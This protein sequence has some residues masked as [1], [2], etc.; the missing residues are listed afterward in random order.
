MK[1]ILLGD[2]ITQG[3]GSRT[4][5]F[6]SALQELLGDGNTVLYG[7]V[8]GQIKPNRRGKI[9]PH[10]PGRLGAENGC[11]ILPRPFYSG[12]PVKRLLQRGENMLRTILRKLVYAVDGTEQWLPIEP[13]MQTLDSACRTLEAMG[14]RPLICSTVHIDERLFPGSDAAYLCYNARMR[15]Y[16][17]EHGLT[18]I[19]IYSV[20]RDHVERDGWS[21]CYNY[22]HFH[23][24]GNGYRL[25]AE[26]IAEGIRSGR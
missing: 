6:Q 22:D 16:A 17:E 8:D 12:D 13:F 26:Q 9:F 7:N 2:S 3:L 21:S 25:M 11:M 5:N 4:V 10:I 20:L 18:F 1:I 24:N 23:P 14:V 19:D 15:T